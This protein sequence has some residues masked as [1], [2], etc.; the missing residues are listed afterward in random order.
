VHISDLAL[1]AEFN[2]A[3]EGV[4]PG[5]VKPTRTTVRADLV[6][7]GMLVE[8]TVIASQSRR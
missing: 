6:V 7:A 4:F 2:A 1:A 8:V 3:Y 5:P